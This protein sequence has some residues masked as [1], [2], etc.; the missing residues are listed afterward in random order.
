MATTLSYF[1]ENNVDAIVFP[2]VLCPPP[3]LGDNAEIEINGQ[4][5]SILK[6]IG[7]NTALG[8]FFRMPGLVLPASMTTSGLPVGIEFEALP[9]RDRN[10]LALGLSVE[11]VLGRLLA[12]K[13]LPG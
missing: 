6:A 1:R 9:G 12:P 8:P 13:V 7:R 10:L 2:P 11:G 5:V 4:M 3:A